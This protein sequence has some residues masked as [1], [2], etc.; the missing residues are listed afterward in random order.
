MQSSP[1]PNVIT[2]FGAILQFPTKEGNLASQ[3]DHQ[4]SASHLYK[5]Y[6]SKGK[7]CNV[8]DVS[9]NTEL[10]S[11]IAKIGPKKAQRSWLLSLFLNDIQQLLGYDR[12]CIR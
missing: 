3:R 9:A 4:E 5:E 2:S 1:S 12:Q 6:K 11:A 7:V 8:I 10:T